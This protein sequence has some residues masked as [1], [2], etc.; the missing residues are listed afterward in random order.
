MTIIST[1]TSAY[2][3]TSNATTQR[4][5]ANS[6]AP[7]ANQAASNTAATADNA[8]PPTTGV[9][10][11]LTAQAMSASKTDLTV[12][13]GQKSFAQVALDA[14]ASMDTQYAAMKA[15]GKPFDINKREGE[16]LYKLLGSLDRRSLYAVR[17]NEG[18]QFTK[19][20]QVLAQI[21]MGKQVA[22]AMDL[23][24]KA[25]T[26]LSSSSNFA[27]GF[28]NGIQIKLPPAKPGVYLY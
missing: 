9:V 12:T 18:G 8:A 4:S 2:A 7:D 19:D 13:G 5:V 10:V 1:A 16:D 22:Y 21:L 17:S 14:R 3:N 23:P 20:E 28:K 15:S 6:I 27:E 11:T 25:G 26:F 24:S